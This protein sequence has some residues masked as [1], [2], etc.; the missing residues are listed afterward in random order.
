MPAASS[1]ARQVDASVAPAGL[2]AAGAPAAPVGTVLWLGEPGAG[3]REVVGGK[4]AGLSRLAARHR[5][6]PG[7]VLALEG[8]ELPAAARSQVTAAYRRLGTLTGE[9]RPAVAVRSSAVDE[10][11]AEASFAGQHDTF[12]NVAGAEQVWWAVARCVAS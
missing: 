6:P 12:L 5:V 3:R 9:E 7:F 10:D 8:A 1:A 11:G 4:A 2:G